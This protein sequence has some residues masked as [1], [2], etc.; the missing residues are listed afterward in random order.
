MSW[1]FWEFIGKMEH[2]NQS[3]SKTIKK[4]IPVLE[5]DAIGDACVP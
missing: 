1:I 4:Y 3:A 2:T 5:R